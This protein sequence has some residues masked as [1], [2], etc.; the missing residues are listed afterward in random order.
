MDRPFREQIQWL[1]VNWSLSGAFAYFREWA[2]LII[3][4]I[5]A[6][7]SPDTAQAAAAI[8]YFTLFSLFP[9]TLLTVAVASLWLDPM[10]AES[11]IIT[12]LEFVAPALGELLGAN[13]QRIVQARGPVTGFALVTLLWS[14][15]NIFNVITRVMDGIWKVSKSRSAW[16]HRGIAILAALLISGLLLVALFAQGTILTIANSLLPAEMEPLRPLTNQFWSAAANVFLFSALYYALPHISLRWRDVLPG[17]VVAGFIWEFA[18]RTFLAFVASYLTRS[19]LVYGSMATIT[20][21]LTWTYFSS[22]I[23]IFGAFLNVEYAR[24][25]DRLF[26]RPFRR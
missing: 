4:P 20:A 10:M 7:F 2:M 25:S 15:S 3:R 16:R 8:S 11:E 14:A 17:A 23:F 1:R 5:Q 19:N 22:L 9:L 18:K 13:I 26:R 6:T 12:Q 24:R 21:F